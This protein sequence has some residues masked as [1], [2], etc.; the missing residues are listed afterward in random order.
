MATF[1]ALSDYEREQWEST[2]AGVREQYFAAVDQL[3]AAAGGDFTAASAGEQDTI[4]AAAEQNDVRRLLFTHAIEGMYANP[5]YGGNQGLA[6]WE[7]IGFAG[8]VAPTGWT[9]AEVTESDG[10][11]PAPANVR[12]P[13]PAEVAESATEGESGPIVSRPKSARHGPGRPHAPHDDLE[14]WFTAAL[15]LLSK[16]RQRAPVERRR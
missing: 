5:E 9:D 14:A 13:F 2:I 8:D 16:A 10:P 11:D 7:D 1:V 6:G 4:L 12:L 3:D 15:P